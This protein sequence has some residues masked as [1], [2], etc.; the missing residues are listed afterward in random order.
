M[1]L[2]PKSFDDPECAPTVARIQQALDGEPVDFA[3]DA[4]A[5]AC[6][7]CRDRVRGIAQLLALGS[8]PTEPVPAGFTERVLTALQSERA[9]APRRALVRY[10]V[11][12]ALAA[13]LLVG[14]YFALATNRPPEV[15][16]QPK[17]SDLVKSEPDVAP[18]PRERPV[19]I[20]DAVAHAGQSLLDAPKPLAESVAVAPKLL[21]ALSGPFAWPAAKP[22]GADVLEP[23]R[24]AVLELPTAAR[25]ALEPV[26]GTAAKAYARFL[27]D[28]GTV[29]PNS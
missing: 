7:A 27:R 20:G 12:A 11:W 23:A 8:A 13:A 6:P 1:S 24:Q 21:D 5:T 19:R 10:S 26:T 18:A 3:T 2:V 22:M 28:L 14:V 16:Q 17:P 25:D 4:H 15:P 29:K 9:S